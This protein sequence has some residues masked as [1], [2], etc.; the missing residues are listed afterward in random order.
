VVAAN[1]PVAFDFAFA[2]KR[3]LMRAKA[4]ECAPPGA[5]THERDIHAVRGQSEGTGAD[6]IARLGDAEEG[7]GFHATCSSVSPPQS[8]W[9]RLATL[10]AVSTACPPDERRILSLRTGL[11]KAAGPGVGR[12]PR[13]CL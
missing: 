9:R 6:K 10:K 13:A 12:I 2:Q 1:E 7:V 5:G 4:L 8:G 11:G 3:A